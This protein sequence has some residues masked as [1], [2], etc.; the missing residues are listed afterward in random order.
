[1]KRR[2]REA[3]RQFSHMA[4]KLEVLVFTWNVGNEQPIAAELEAWLPKGGDSYDLVV[5]GTQENEF[6]E[7][8]RESADEA[9]SDDE[10]ATAPE[11][12]TLV[13]RE[14][15]LKQRQERLAAAKAASKIDSVW[16]KMVAERLGPGYGVCQHQVMRGMRLT[17][18]AK[19]EHLDGASA[20]ISGVE[21]GQSATGLG[22]V[23]ANKGGIL[24]KLNY[25]STSLAFISSHLAAHSHKLDRRNA[26]CLE[27]CC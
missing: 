3:A 23:F 4:P 6:K 7:K 21:V 20:C 27:V 8:K 11:D 19:K 13:E 9:D 15:T 26:D 5:V 14:V 25:G 2:T 10:A 24:I 22:H 1:M 16:D 17:L 18:Y 12:V